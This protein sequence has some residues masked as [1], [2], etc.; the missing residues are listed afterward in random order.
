MTKKDAVQVL[1]IMLEADGGY[2]TH[3]SSSLLYEFINK[4]PEHKKLSSDMFKEKF[5]E[6]L[7]A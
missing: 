7:D 3:C 6:E 4:Y 5:E 1:N 2:C